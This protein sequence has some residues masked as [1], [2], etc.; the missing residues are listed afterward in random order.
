MRSSRSSRSVCPVNFTVRLHDVW[1][2]SAGGADLY[3]ATF[4]DPEWRLT[5]VREDR[6]GVY[7]L[8]PAAHDYLE[9]AGSWL[10]HDQETPFVTGADEVE[11]HLALLGEAPELPTTGYQVIGPCCRGRPPSS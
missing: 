7:F 5:T 9:V 6:L 3:L 11:R 8:W 2:A 4:R 10:E 1:R